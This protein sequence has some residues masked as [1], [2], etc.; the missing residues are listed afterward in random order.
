MRAF[1][2][3]SE[4]HFQL[5]SYTATIGNHRGTDIVLQRS[6]PANPHAALEFSPSDNSFILGDFNSL[7]GTFVS[8]CQVQNAAGGCSELWHRFGPSSCWW[9]E[10][11][12]MKLWMLLPMEGCPGKV[13]GDV[14]GKV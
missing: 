3:G 8:S 1:P 4:G 6:Q 5:K 2:K 11:L 7:H 10:L 13:G 9:M 12:W 14:Q